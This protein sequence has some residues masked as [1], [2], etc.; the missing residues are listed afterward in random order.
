MSILG[1]S[2]NTLDSVQ[3]WRSSQHVDSRSIDRMPPAYRDLSTRR[4]PQVSRSF[5]STDILFNNQT[6]DHDT[7]TISTGDGYQSTFR[8]PLGSGSRP[9]D[10]TLSQPT[11]T[12]YDT[13][14][15]RAAPSDSP[16][17][18][19]RQ[20]SLACTSCVIYNSS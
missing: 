19:R 14:I 1:D 3:L 9:G 2:R 5:G 11:S 6:Q 17:Q 10:E 18:R 16:L 15:L 7:L 12:I 8:P 20:A 4:R 13:D